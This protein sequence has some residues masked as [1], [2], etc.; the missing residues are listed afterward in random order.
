L[1]LEFNI[2]IIASSHVK[3]KYFQ[4]LLSILGSKGIMHIQESV[5]VHLSKCRTSRTME[6]SLN[7]SGTEGNLHWKTN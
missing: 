5:S 1:C 6:W 7:K 2:E 4:I 3:Y